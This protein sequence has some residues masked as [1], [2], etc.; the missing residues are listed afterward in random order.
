MAVTDTQLQDT[1]RRY[2]STPDSFS[3]AQQAALA[4]I[5]G[6][7]VAAQATATAQASHKQAGKAKEVATKA[8]AQAHT[9]LDTTLAELETREAALPQDDGV[10]IAELNL[11]RAKAVA[12]YRP[13]HRALEQATDAD[14]TA[15]RNLKAAE[16][17]EARWA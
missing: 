11:A 1:L 8:E 12:G 14:D 4:Q 7:L 13:S 3:E 10:A 9:I 6:R 17:E 15:A 16:S 5:Q 2:R